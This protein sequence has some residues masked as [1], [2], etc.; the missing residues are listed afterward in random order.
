MGTKRDPVEAA[1][2]LV[3]LPCGS[4][5]NL[6]FYATS[7]PITI[8]SGPSHV[9]PW[10]FGDHCMTAPDVGISSVHLRL[11]FEPR[12]RTYE[13]QVMGSS[14][15]RVDG[16]EYATG[17]L[18]RLTSGS[19]VRIGGQEICVLFPLPTKG[20]TPLKAAASALP[21]VR[22]T[23]PPQLGI[24]ELAVCALSEATGFV[25]SSGEIEQWIRHMY[26][27]VAQTIVC[28]SPAC[29][30]WRASLEAALESKRDVFVARD[31]E[32]GE[33]GAGPVWRLVNPPRPAPPTPRP[34]PRTRPATRCGD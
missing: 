6:C 27:Y 5:P 14:G 34:L 33:R 29:D 26:P 10:G 7:L 28:P 12:S 15:A 16:H 4:C 22:A 30:A 32:P 21:A 17:T 23:G 2:K 20:P 13:L 25:L 1:A 31:R 18:V 3:G 11:I 24:P 19:C 8:G 9:Q